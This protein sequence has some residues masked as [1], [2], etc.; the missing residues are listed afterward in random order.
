MARVF[1]EGVEF[2]FPQQSQL[3]GGISFEM[4]RG[5][6]ALV[7]ANGAGKTTLLKVLAGQLKPD[8]GLVQVGRCTLVPQEPEYG[9]V[10]AFSQAWDKAALRWRAL[11]ALEY[12]DEAL[13]GQLSPGERQRWQLGAAFWR[14]PE[15]LLLDEPTNHLDGEGRRRLGAAMAAFESDGGVGVVVSHDRAFL[16]DVASAVVRLHRGVA[17]LYGRR[18]SE[19]APVW[20][21]AQAAM[22]AELSRAQ[23]SLRQAERQLAGISEVHRGAERSL[24]IRARQKNSGD[25]DAST[26]ARKFRAERAE[27]SHGR[28]KQVSRA[29]AERVRQRVET[30]ARPEPT[31]GALKLEASGFRGAWVLRFSDEV[32]AGDQVL[33]SA[34]WNVPREAR[35][36]LR[37]PNGAGKTSL[38]RTALAGCEAPYLWISQE[39]GLESILASWK[40]LDAE[41][42]SR[43]RQICA[44]LLLA[45]PAIELAEQG[46]AMSPGMLRKFALGVGLVARP[47]LV[48]LDEPTNDLDMPSIERLEAVLRQFRGALV[49][50]SHDEAFGRALGLE[51]VDLG[52]LKK[53][54]T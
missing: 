49:V 50:V 2:A 21:A 3:F 46:V 18:L 53:A 27:G 26:M 37:G 22:V 19:A 10:E 20:E 29:E 38:L 9:F 8:R 42:R 6:T 39:L 41:Q 35:V 24:S 17:T 4:T 54:E 14:D 43:V 12:V 48:V 5:W 23:E 1:V 25:R 28:A 52:E 51:E 33:F 47:A 11:F 32:R 36:W 7:G 30:L 40:A 34:T 45:S 13:W 44:A 31:G 16:E 15:V